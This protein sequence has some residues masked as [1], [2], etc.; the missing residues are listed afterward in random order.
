MKFNKS[1]VIAAVAALLSVSAFT[2]APEADSASASEEYA[3]NGQ[4]CS[5][6]GCC[7]SIQVNESL[8][9]RYA[10]ST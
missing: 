8:V 9:H 5:P 7:S 6:S 1:I 4:W 10:T 2:M 3:V